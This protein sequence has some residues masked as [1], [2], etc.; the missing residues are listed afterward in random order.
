[1][2]KGKERRAKDRKPEAGDRKPV[3]GSQCVGVSVGKKPEIG[4][5]RSET[6]DRTTDNRDDRQPLSLHNSFKKSST[7][8]SASRRIFLSNPRPKS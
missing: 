3:L 4:G 1:M 8:S 2:A 6:G 7:V 5:Q